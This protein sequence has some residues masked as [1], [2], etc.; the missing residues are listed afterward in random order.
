MGIFPSLTCFCICHVQEWY[1]ETS[2]GFITLPGCLM[3]H[4]SM[5]QCPKLELKHCSTEIQNEAWGEKSGKRVI[6]C[7][8]AAT[9]LSCLISNKSAQIKFVI[10]Q[11]NFLFLAIDLG[12]I[13]S[14]NQRRAPR[15]LIPGLGQR[16]D[17][18]QAWF[19]RAATLHC[20]PE[21]C[22]SQGLFFLPR[23]QTAS[24]HHLQCLFF[25]FGKLTMSETQT[26]NQLDKVS[27]KFSFISKF[28]EL[29]AWTLDLMMNPLTQKHD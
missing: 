16:S 3:G 2:D 9:H 13:Q 28:Q 8:D 19:M 29:S 20:L 15:M 18:R 22:L 6:K 11:H 1:C 21:L 24:R 5:I 7:A 27:Y 17:L 12:Q 14:R 23:S 26:K 4:W 25:C 10:I